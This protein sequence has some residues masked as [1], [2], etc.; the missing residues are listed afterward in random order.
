LI[1]DHCGQKITIIIWVALCMILSGCG[2]T[3]NTQGETT[4]SRIAIDST[5][6]E[7][8]HDKGGEELLGIA[9]SEPFKQNGSLCQYTYNVLICHNPFTQGTGRF[10]FYP[11]GLDMSVAESPDPVPD[12]SK[13]LVVDG[14][15]ISND[16]LNTY[17]N[18]GGAD[19]M[20]RPLTNPKIN[21]E[22]QRLEQYFEKAG[23][24]HGLNE[25]SGVAHL[26]PYGAIACG[27][28]CSVQAALETPDGPVI[29]SAAPFMNVIERLGGTDIYG[30]AL[31]EPYETANNE[32]EQVYETIVVF[33]SRDNPSVVHFRPISRSLGM[34]TLPPVTR[35]PT[36]AKVVFHVI[37]GDQ[38]YHVPI[39]FEE[40]IATHGG[41]EMSGQPIADT[42]RYA[43]DGN[44]IRQ[45]FESYCLDY[46]PEASAAF[47]VRLAPL[48][49]R[50]IEKHGKPQTV[51][52]SPVSENQPASS[53]LVVNVSESKPQLPNNEPQQINAFIYDKN[54]LKPQ[55]GIE[56]KL[57]I[58]HPDRKQ[59]VYYMPP[60]RADGWTSITISPMPQM[61]NGTVLPYEVCTKKTAPPP[62]CIQDSFLIWNE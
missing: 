33:S 59:F 50:Y 18:L 44:V 55:Q 53:N 37:N 10:G 31:T 43:S 9:I 56:L 3:S 20:G 49:N 1:K 58:T 25:A 2:L 23:L 35:D 5:L 45:C 38:G 26:L 28:R 6:R 57:A 11:L 15:L 14:Y 8:Y 39:V 13:G 21:Y 19:G 40:F 27:T 61:P 46:H 51:T 32:I 30:V 41:M 4:V 34:F 29:Q 42:I 60:T 52:P 22:K 12:S 36:Q 48:G 17:Q 47:Q 7:F 24:Y 54:T 16:L 62:I